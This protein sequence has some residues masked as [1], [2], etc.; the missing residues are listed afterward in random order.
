MNTSSLDTTSFDH[1]F[2]LFMQNSKRDVKLVLKQQ[3]KLLTSDCC[4]LTPPF[5]KAVFGSPASE[6]WPT[7]LKIGEHAVRT[8]IQGLFYSIKNLDVVKNPRKPEVKAALGWMIEQGNYE[9]FKR[10][11]RTELKR[12]EWMAERASVQAHSKFRNRLGRVRKNA[13]VGVFV[14][15]SIGQLLTFKLSHVGAAKAGWQTAAQKFGVTLPRWITRHSTPGSAQ[16]DT[17]N[18]TNPSITIQNS[19]SYAGALAADPSARIIE[20]ALAFRARA[21][22]RQVENYQN[23]R[24]QEFSR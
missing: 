22:M 1:A 7:Q 15:D 19:V 11:M 21:M 17:D 13:A 16:D 4:K 9:A 14:E 6:S 18:P 24:A 12:S 8:Q 20:R 10:Y 5:S 3:A 2:G 23:K